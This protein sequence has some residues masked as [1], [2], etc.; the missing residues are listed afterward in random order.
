M[1]SQLS[2][3]ERGMAFEVLIT[4][5][6]FSHGNI[7]KAHLYSLMGQDK[8]SQ[9]TAIHPDFRLRSPWLNERILHVCYAWEGG[10]AAWLRRYSAGLLTGDHEFTQQECR[11]FFQ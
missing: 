7:K 5:L 11:G 2:I 9:Q 8:H 10:G 1:T 6:I 4:H 3:T